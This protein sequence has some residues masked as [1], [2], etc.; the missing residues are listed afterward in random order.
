MYILILKEYIKYQ[1]IQ[2]AIF[3]LKAGSQLHRSKRNAA[4]FALM[5]LCETGRSPGD[6]FT[7][8]YGCFCGFGGKGNQPV[9]AIDR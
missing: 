5:V 9:D 2:S 6:L 8:G 1:L 3:F 4:Q 7:L